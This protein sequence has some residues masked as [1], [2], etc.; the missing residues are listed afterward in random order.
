[1]LDDRVRAT[2]ARLEAEDR[3][4][5]AAGLRGCRRA[6][7]RAR[8]SRRPGASSSGS[9]PHRPGSRSWR[10]A[11]LAATRPSGSRRAL[12]SSV[13]G[14]SLWS[15]IRRRSPPGGPI[16]PRRGSRSGRSSSR[17]TPATRCA[18]PRTSSTSSS[19]TRRRTT[20]RRS[21]RSRGLFSSRGR[22]SSRTTSSRMG[23]RS[24]V[25][26]RPA[27]RFEP[28]LGDGRARPRPRGDDRSQRAGAEG[29]TS[30]ISPCR[31]RSR[32]GVSD[33]PRRGAGRRAELSADRHPLPV[34]MLRVSAE[35][36]WS[37]LSDDSSGSGGTSG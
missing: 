7:A 13:D 20:T 36:R 37:G 21:S 14:S 15:M 34:R 27:G 16:S 10:S 31:F 35:R 22:S 19:S 26:G 12:A 4:E 1:M 32:I 28:E 23:R 3:D 29:L 24:S 5:R 18:A 30:A 8:S 9:Q 11:G 25:L 6:S 2:L 33:A 17:V